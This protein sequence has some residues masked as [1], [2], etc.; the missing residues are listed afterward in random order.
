MEPKAANWHCVT[1]TPQQLAMG[2][3]RSLAKQATELYLA[4]GK[5]EGMAL[6]AT[7]LNEAGEATVYFTPAAAAGMSALLETYQAAP[8]PAPTDGEHLAVIAGDLA[9]KQQLLS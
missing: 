6:V 9:V 3:K 4:Q 7:G 8:C 2:V 5:P 1:L